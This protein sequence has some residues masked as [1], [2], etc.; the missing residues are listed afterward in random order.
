MTS[1]PNDGGR[2][3]PPDPVRPGPRRADDRRVAVASVVIAAGFLLVA[4]AAALAGATGAATVPPWLPLHLA[5]AGGASTAIAGVMPFFVAAL[6]AGHPAPLRLRVAAVALV[7]VGAAL[8]SVRGVA[9]STG[10]LPVIGGCVYLAGV[11]AVALT[12]RA[13]GR[14]GLM[15]RRP[16]VIAGYSLALLNVAIGASLG[17]LAAAGWLPVIDRWAELRPAHAWTNVIGFVSL[18]IISTLLHFLPTVLGTRIVP[19]ASAILAVL[20]PAVAAPLVVTGQLTG[21]EAVAGGGAVVAMTGAGALALEASRVYRTRGTWT[22]DP[23]WHRMAG[24]GL[25][26]GVGWFAL[27]T[28]LAS[29]LVLAAALGLIGSGEAWSSALVAAPLALGWA[30]QV[31]IASWTHLLPSIGP[32]GP[33]EHA[34]QREVLGR[35]AT[36]RLVALNA[37]AALLAVGWPL[38]IGALAGAGALLAAGAVVLSVGLAASALRARARVRPAGVRWPG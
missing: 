15:M 9:P 13:S 4:A 21:L 36:P 10:V 25:L 34:V 31:L 29:A 7:A 35:A 32:G 14:T 23:A 30:V 16:I 20:A 18:V 8:V 38:G 24:M 12:V 26:A 6:A 3:A 19:R 1:S 33:V 22:T 2:A 17:T 27:G 28:G 37:G 5:L 11:G